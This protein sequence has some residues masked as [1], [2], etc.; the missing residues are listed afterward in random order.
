M[1][2]N[3]NMKTNDTIFEFTDNFVQ[4]FDKPHEVQKIE[5]IKPEQ[6]IQNIIEKEKLMFDSG[7]KHSEDD[8]LQIEDRAID[9][10]DEEPRV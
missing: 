7:K 3:I 2:T 10:V 1:L 6:Q 4:I 9:Q 5:P 8:L